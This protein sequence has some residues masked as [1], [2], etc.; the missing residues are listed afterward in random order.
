MGIEFEEKLLWKK[1]AT[2][3]MDKISLRWDFG[4]FVE[5]RARS[6]EFWVATK[7]GGFKARSVMSI[8][9]EDPVV[10]GQ[11]QVGQKCAVAPV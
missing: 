8:P 10:A 4:I 6:G 2:A 1:K 3:K 11:R 5:V 9:T 7:Q